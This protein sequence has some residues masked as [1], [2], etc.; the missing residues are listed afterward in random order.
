MLLRFGFGSVRAVFFEAAR[1]GK[2]TQAMADHV[3]GDKHGVEN[4]AVMNTEGHADKIGRDHRTARPGLDRCLRL[5]VLRLDDFF[6]Q[7]A[8]HERAFFN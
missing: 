3:L 7:V 5:G 6:H 8:I 4:L 1:Q 2:L